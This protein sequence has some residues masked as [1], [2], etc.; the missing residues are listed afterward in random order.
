VQ[1]LL[2]SEMVVRVIKNIIRQQ[3]RDIMKESKYLSEEQV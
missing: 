1:K 3:F 2:L